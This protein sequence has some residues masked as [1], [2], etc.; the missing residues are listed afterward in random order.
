M[1]Y[2]LLAA[3]GGGLI[4]LSGAYFYQ[5]LDSVGMIHTWYSRYYS[6][7]DIRVSL[8]LGEV[9]LSINRQ[10]RVSAWKIYNQINTRI[11]AVEFNEEYDSFL[12]T[13]K[14]LHTLFGIIRDELANIPVDRIKDEDNTLVNFYHSILNEGIRPYLS[15]WHIPVSHFV[16][17]QNASSIESILEVE[18]KF[19]KRKEILEDIKAMNLR[20]KSYSSELMKIIKG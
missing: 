9:N 3:I 12:H 19:P 18:K 13:N 11:A 17:K 4:V 7:A 8:P 6:T 20:M 15:K 1:F 2:I 14:S 5:K 10:D 16:E